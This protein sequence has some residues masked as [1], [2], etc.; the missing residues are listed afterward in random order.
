MSVF[1]RRVQR[2]YSRGDM[3][4]RFGRRPSAPPLY[5][6]FGDAAAYRTPLII[7][8]RN[9]NRHDHLTLLL[10]VQLVAMG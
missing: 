8:M 9:L 3:H 2:G 5:S 4:H 7:N 6:D 1:R 10:L